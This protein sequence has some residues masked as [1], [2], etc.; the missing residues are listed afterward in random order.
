M[1]IPSLPPSKAALA[2]DNSIR[3]YHPENSLFLTLL[4]SFATAEDV[5]PTIG[6]GQVSRMNGAPM[7]HIGIHFDGTNLEAHVDDTVATPLLRALTDP[8]TFNDSESWSVLSDKHHNFQYGWIAEGIWSPPVGAAVWVEE[9][10]STS[11]LEVYEGGR[12]MS[13]ST[14]RA[15]TFDPIFGT[16][17]SNAIWKWGGVMTHNAY[18]VANPTL[19]E[20]SATYRV[21]LGD[22]ATG[23]ELTDAAGDPL[24]GSNEV[25]LTFASSVPE[26]SAGWMGV[27]AALFGF[28]STRPR[29]K[30]R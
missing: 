4:P 20:Y 12:F 25:T 3:V 10:G 19:P 17:G 18:A 28:A 7:K 14:I 27:T 1:I 9:I 26:P 8:D 6:G 23:L 13:E 30:T 11:E 29:R 2:R 21:Y 22:E 15:M 5:L 24:Y 16:G